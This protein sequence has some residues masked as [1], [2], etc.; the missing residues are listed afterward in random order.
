MRKIVM[1]KIKKD[2]KGSVTL[3]VLVT[4]MF[5]L[6]VVLLANVNIINKKNGQKK[7]VNQIIENYK[8]SSE[9][10]EKAYDGLYKET[11][12][13]VVLKGDTLCF[14]NNKKDAQK[15]ADEDYGDVKDCVFKRSYSQGPDTPWY[16]DRLKIKKVEFC[17]EIRPIHMACYFSDLS[18][19]TEII[20]LENLHTDQVTSMYALFYNC[21]SIPQIDVSNFKTSNVTTMDAMFYHCTVVSNITG[22]NNLDTSKVTNMNSMFANCKGLTTI[23]ISNFDM[24]SVA[25]MG[26]MFQT[27]SNLQSI[28][29]S[30]NVDTEKL[31]FM[32]GMFNGCASL[33]DLDVS[34]F[35]TQKVTDMYCLFS[36]CSKLSQIDIS[37]WD[38]SNVTTMDNMFAECTSLSNL[39]VSNFNTEKVTNMRFMFYS[40]LEL[41]ELDVSNFKTQNVT[42]MEAMFMSMNKVR[43]IIFSTDFKTHNVTTMA[44]MFA[45]CNKLTSLDLSNFDTT[46]VTTMKQMFYAC[47]QLASIDVSSWKTP[48]VQEFT[49]M[50]R[51]CAG[52]KVLNCNG[53][54][55]KGGAMAGDMF[56]GCTNITDLNIS[57][58]DLSKAN[59][60]A[61]AFAYVPNNA[62]IIT[63]KAMKTWI[64]TV[65]NPNSNANFTNIETID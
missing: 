52:L 8:V 44:N 28:K 33:V 25:E 32:R 26:Y 38:T 6:V 50:F 15:D 23:D 4:S 27:S 19:L 54:T 61:W 55:I 64:Q 20:G 65:Y 2:Q 31:T 29:F 5:F 22:L 48:N 3:F 7:Q 59:E 24:S 43:T 17:T 14:Y 12:V 62:K 49:S 16:K 63:N 58:M 40:C 10:L 53:F 42:D 30:K 41:T 56:N 18:A 46:K 60:W 51:G 57:Q 11:A 21:K 36:K 45:N 39:N 35:N 9:E 1:K 37:N 47:S 34:K 13:Y